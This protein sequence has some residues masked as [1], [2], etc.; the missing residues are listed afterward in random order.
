MKSSKQVS[1]AALVLPL[2]LAVGCTP[3]IE[4]VVV[5]QITDP[6]LPAIASDD[7]FE[8]YEGTA[9]GFELQAFTESPDDPKLECCG[10]DCSQQCRRFDNAED[11]DEVGVTG[12][13]SVSVWQIE[14]RVYVVV[15]ERVGS[16][17][18]IVTAE[19]AE[20]FY[21]IPVTVLEQPAPDPGP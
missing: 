4:A 17:A 21:E 14:E 1:I 12:E 11:P 5:E 16:G 8:I 10:A 15:A 19:D 7:R 20:G 2:T 18:I 3:N 13:G 9:V 6:P